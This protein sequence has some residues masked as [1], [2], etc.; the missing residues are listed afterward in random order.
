MLAVT[1]NTAQKHTIA[2]SFKWMFP[3]PNLSPSVSYEPPTLRSLYSYTGEQVT[4]LQ[5]S[6][7]PR[8]RDKTAKMVRAK[9]EQQRVRSKL[10]KKPNIPT[11]HVIMINN[12]PVMKIMSK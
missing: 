1:H 4:R 7:Y 3:S 9:E 11:P 5:P 8:M 2:P 10:F 6:V 12:L